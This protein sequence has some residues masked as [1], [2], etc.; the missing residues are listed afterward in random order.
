MQNES[1][2]NGT[3]AFPATQ[4]LSTSGISNLDLPAQASEL[5]GCQ[6]NLHGRDIH[7]LA[8]LAGDGFCAYGYIFY[9]DV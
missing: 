2:K 3:G 7:G 8:I 9:N 4:P 5:A 6:Q 1:A